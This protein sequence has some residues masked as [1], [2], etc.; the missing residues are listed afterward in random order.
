MKVTRDSDGA[1]IEVPSAEVP[2]RSNQ[3]SGPRRPPRMKEVPLPHPDYEFVP[4]LT[5]YLA[6]PKD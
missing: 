1:E 5:G 6:V 2:I 3:I 4:T